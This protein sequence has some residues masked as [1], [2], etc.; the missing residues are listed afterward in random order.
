MKLFRFAIILTIKHFWFFLKEQYILKKKLIIFDIDGTLLYSNRIDSQCFADTYEKVYQSK[1]PTIDWSKYPHVTDDTIF[2]TV[3]QDHFQREATSEEMHDFQNEFVASIKV[4]REEQPHEFKEVPNARKMI[5][6]L[7]RND[8]YEVGI[9]TGGWRRPAIVKLNHIGIPTSDL[10]MSF[11]DGN[12]TREDII[13]GV[14][15]Q[16]DAKEMSFEKIV[17]VGDAAW[18]VRTTRNM[19]IP[20]IGVRREGDADFL[21]QLGADTVIRDYKD[22]NLFLSSIESSKVPKEGKKDFF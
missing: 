6:H 13:N 22:I 15:L 14:L 1:F 17:Y 3:I 19:D 2:K 7:L 4:K 10:H 9:A 8:I 12:P 5:E 18:D 11:A 20:F 16:T 21:K